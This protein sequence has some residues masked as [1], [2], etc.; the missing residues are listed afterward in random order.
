MRTPLKR[1]LL[2]LVII[3]LLNFPISYFISNSFH[4]RA[5]L[6]WLYYINEQS[7]DY[8]VL[9]SSR[10][11][12]MVDINTLDK[13][14]DKNGINLGSIGGGYSE[15]YVVISKFLE[16]NDIN[17]L[18]LNIDGYSLN[19]PLGLGNQPF[20]FFGFLPLFES[21]KYEDVFA[22]N[23]PKWKYYLW[24]VVPIIKYI[25]Y[26]DRIALVK[27][28]HKLLDENKGTIYLEETAQFKY[29]LEP[30]IAN[31]I[32]LK[33]LNVIINLCKENSIELVLI[34]TPIYSPDSVN[35]GTSALEIIKSISKLHQIDYHGYDNLI[36]Y[37]NKSYFQNQ[38][39]TLKSGAIE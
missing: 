10:A 32:D 24:K 16:T 20:H 2:L 28:S 1:C 3:Y 13:Y 17:T 35:N 4:T 12:N 27:Q 33:Y 22:D 23:L 25:E 11:Y 29:L 18:I 30:S 34:T 36:D 7:Y 38:T 26:N 31:E 39:H 5:K 8:A 14:L 6:D 9:G 15:N 21:S 19:S 37:T